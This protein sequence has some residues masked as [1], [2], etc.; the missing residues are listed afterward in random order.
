[1]MGPMELCAH[2][3]LHHGPLDSICS[4]AN[5]IF[6]KPGK[7]LM[8]FTSS[9]RAHHMRKSHA[10][11][12]LTL[13]WCPCSDREIEFENS[14]QKAKL[15]CESRKYME[16]SISLNFAIYAPPKVPPWKSLRKANLKTL[17][18]Y[19][20]H[21]VKYRNCTQLKLIKPCVKIKKK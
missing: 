17:D 16:G 21:A 20:A 8:C 7:N 3:R 10:W 12:S 4:S 18:K 19:A 9:Q 15:N 2:T 13:R 6:P 5:R 11:C 1:M 14:S